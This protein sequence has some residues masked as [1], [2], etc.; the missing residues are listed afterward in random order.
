MRS[1][2]NLV[3]PFDWRFTEIDPDALATTVDAE[4]A[5]FLGHFPD[6]PVVPGVCLIELADRAARNRGMAASA[7]VRIASAKFTD[8]VLPADR[9]TV[10]LSRDGSKVTAV[11]RTDRGENCR[12]VLDYE[13]S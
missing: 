10:Q 5:V 8:A 12:I 3:I 11:V 2:A 6:H 13:A 7:L 9:L 4:S 1:A